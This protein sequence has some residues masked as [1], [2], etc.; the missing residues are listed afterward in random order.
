MPI[1][2]AS[3]IEAHVT[4]SAP[5]GTIECSVVGSHISNLCPANQPCSNYDGTSQVIPLNLP[6]VA[7]G[8]II[9]ASQEQIAAY[10]SSS[11]IGMHMTMLWLQLSLS[12]PLGGQSIYNIQLA[13]AEAFL[14][15][16]EVAPPPATD[17]PTPVPT[18]T[19][20]VNP[21]ESPNTPTATVTQSPSSPT[22]T[23]PSSSPPTTTPN[24]PM[25]TSAPRTATPETFI[26]A[27]APRTAS[28]TGSQVPPS[29]NDRARPSVTPK[30]P[31]TG[32]STEAKRGSD[33]EMLLLSL[34]F[35]TLLGS[36]YSI[37]RSR[38]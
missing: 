23:S 1:L 14:G 22:P 11:G 35:F 32:D 10:G 9:I 3:E 21:P 36:G 29:P 33:L 19:V 17:T 12:A 16:V 13:D 38:K 6:G 2:T 24:A 30:P 27:G 28:P 5:E 37:I 8:S 31:R 34:G 26:P 18:P 20:V 4:C 15:D 7:S 25:P